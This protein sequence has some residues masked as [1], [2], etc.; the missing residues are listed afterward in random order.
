MPSSFHTAARKQ[1]SSQ[2]SA[3]RS[4]LKRLSPASLGRRASA[5][6]APLERCLGAAWAPRGQ[7][8]AAADTCTR[9][10]AGTSATPPGVHPPATRLTLARHRAHR[11]VGEGGLTPREGR[12]RE[13][14]GR[15]AWHARRPRW[16]GGG[17]GRLGPVSPPLR[18]HI[19]A[20]QV[21]VRKLAQLL[22][23]SFVLM[24]SSV[25]FRVPPLCRIGCVI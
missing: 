11:I 25:L 12:R 1:R 10:H 21:L 24:M 15:A 19:I 23:V 8:R 20:L 4:S 3:S 7:S 13:R 18:G 14:G 16:V 6:R 2:T 22:C 5:A 9:R 17:V